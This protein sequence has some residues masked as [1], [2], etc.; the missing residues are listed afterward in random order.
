MSQIIKT[1]KLFT[2]IGIMA[3]IIGYLFLLYKGYNLNK[4]ISLKKDTT[5]KLDEK[6]AKQKEEIAILE[7]NTAQFKETIKQTDS[8]LVKIVASSSDFNTV[9][10]GDQ[11]IKDLGI[12]KDKYFTK[13]SKDNANIDSAKKYQEDGFQFLLNQ[14]VNSAINSFIKSENSYNGYSRVYEIAKYLTKNKE[15]LTDKNSIFWKDV[16][17]IILS[18]YSWKMPERFKIK[19][20]D[21]VK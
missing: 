5:Q 17:K 6:I 20:Q 14:D 11:L 9:K 21:K 8:G 2:V 16:Y 10:Q 4:E 7:K 18:D 12:P 1:I 15:R 13:T 19:L 3:T